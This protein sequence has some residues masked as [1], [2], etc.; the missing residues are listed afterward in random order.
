MGESSLQPTDL[1][2]E[3]VILNCNLGRLNL[4]DWTAPVVCTKSAEL[5][6]K[7]FIPALSVTLSLLIPGTQPT[8]IVIIY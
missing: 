6:N 3:H 4:D 1:N 8:V 7:Y 5:I 2:S